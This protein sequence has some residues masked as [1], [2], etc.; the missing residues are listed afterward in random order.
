MTIISDPNERKI[1][2]LKKNKNDIYKEQSDYR[3]KSLTL[4]TAKTNYHISEQ[5][6]LLSFQNIWRLGI[7][8][9]GDGLSN[10]NRD[11]QLVFTDFGW[12]LIKACNI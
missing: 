1:E 2:L 5:E 10:L 11:K 7:C 4:E 3:K 12:S 9:H 6:G 8:D